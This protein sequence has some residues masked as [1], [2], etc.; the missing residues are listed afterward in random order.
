MRIL[1][2]NRSAAPLAGGMNQYVLDVAER[3]QAAGE[4]VALVH[5]RDPR[6][7]FKGT[8]YVFNHL[9]ANMA[10]PAEVRMRLEALVEDFDPD[11]IQLHGVE[12]S[13]LNEWLA[14]MAPTVRFIH[15]HKF[16]C[17]GGDMT[18]SVPRQICERAHGRHCLVSHGLHGCGSLNP[19]KNLTSYKRVSR[20]LASLAPLHG[21]Q[22]ASSVIR[23]NLIRNG[24]PAEKIELLPLYSPAPQ[25]EKLP[26][27]TG[28]RMILHVGG[29]LRKKGVWM[30][31]RGLP[32]LPE[33]VE[34]VFAGG[35][36]QKESVSDFVKHNRL[37]ERVRV[38]GDLAP[39]E[40]SA[41]YHQASLV[42][43]PSRWNEPLGLAGLQAMAHGKAVVA[44]RCLGISEWLHDGRNGVLVEF[45]NAR[46]FLSVIRD[47]LSR[48]ARLAE[49]GKRGQELWNE[50]FR[51]EAHVQ[52][53]RAY[54]QKI[55]A[56]AQR[57]G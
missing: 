48:P 53:L 40:W 8:G 9:D 17:S 10:A 27:A 18:W 19:L 55:A 50:R 25:A 37:G 45:N 11:V 3:L 15:S 14:A 47:L 52:R 28:R 16:Y 5:G 42:V 44:F 54:Y 13:A 2:L 33:D 34:L 32:S 36:D 24:V 46:E 31:L 38:M 21:I 6:S 49:M 12:N 57:S 39:E 1:L 26:R 30:L 20:A 22:V 7:R 35:G 4:T 41:L 43:M 56:T 51:P 23:E 29:L